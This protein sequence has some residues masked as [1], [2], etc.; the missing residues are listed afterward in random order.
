MPRRDGTG[1]I[2]TEAMTGRGLGFC[3]GTN[4]AV[5]YGTGRRMRLGLGFACGRGFSHGFGRGIVVNQISSKT[6][7]A[8]LQ[9]QKD[10]L[11]NRLEIIDK[12][13][14]CL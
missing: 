11:Q 6:E 1:P 9:E 2:G 7:K 14:E 5:K 4:E 3:T 12:Q 8:L 10:I 13:L